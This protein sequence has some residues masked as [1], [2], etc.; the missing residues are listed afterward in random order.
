MFATVFKTG[1]IGA[2]VGLALAWSAPAALA[3][4]D[5]AGSVDDTAAGLVVA[6]GSRLAGDEKRT[7]FVVDVDRHVAFGVFALADPYRIVVDLPETE[8]K[9]DAAEGRAGRGLVNAYRFG[10]IGP[11]KSRIVLDTSGPVQV[12]KAFVVDAV[13]DQPARLVVDMVETTREDFLAEL[14]L[15]PPRQPVASSP[16]VSGHEAVRPGGASGSR[17]IVVVIDPGH[18]GIDPGARSRSGT[19]EK[20]V[21]LAFSKRL[22]ESLGK[23]GRFEVHL[24]RDDDEF[25]PLA[26]RVNI[27]RNHKASLLISVHADSVATGTVSGATIYTLS[28]RASDGVAA[29]LA[30]QENRSDAIAGVDL[31]GETDAVAD[32]LID[33][34]QRETKNYAVF[35]ARTL[36]EELKGHTGVV[37]NPH[38]S[39]GFRVL[40]AHDVPSVLLELGYLTNPEDEKH[41]L[42][43]EW[44]HK[45]A[46]SVANAVAQYFGERHARAPF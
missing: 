12:D 17:E 34:V 13:D 10:L 7:R 2:L 14:A 42:D 18:G 38:R 22:E 8:F 40:K 39:A 5:S 16:P 4:E 29:A 25:I 30:E 35:F 31:T 32:I 24:T 15:Q 33:L 46:D 21:V 37:K 41:L 19:L 26:E 11:G 27:A 45:I 9:L 23:S 28:E 43:E 1:S 3:E 36:V 20:D 6:T 44:Q